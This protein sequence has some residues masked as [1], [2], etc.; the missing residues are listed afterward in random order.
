MRVTCMAHGVS[1]MGVKRMECGV[2]ALHSTVYRRAWRI[3]V[4]IPV[5][6]PATPLRTPIVLAVALG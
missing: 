6:Y 4:G 1:D 3:R 5:I 2:H